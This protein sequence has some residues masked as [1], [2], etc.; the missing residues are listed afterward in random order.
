MFY[1]FLMSVSLIKSINAWKVFSGKSHGLTLRRSWAMMQ[2]EEERGIFLSFEEF[3]LQFKV[4]LGYPS[5]SLTDQL[6]KCLLPFRD[7]KDSQDSSKQ[8]I[9]HCSW[10]VSIQRM[11]NFLKVAHI[12]CSQLR[13]CVAQNFRLFS[14]QGFAASRIIPNW[15]G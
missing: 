6:I 7:S 12:R 4:F 5:A 2:L 14:L 15:N 8:L 1:W 9:K 11:V 3:F 10:W 13:L